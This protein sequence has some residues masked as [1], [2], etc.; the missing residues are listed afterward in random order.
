MSA[1]NLTYTNKSYEVV[2]HIVQI[3]LPASATL[4][5][6]LGALW[7]LPRA[8]EVS[9]TITALALFLGVTLLVSNKNYH[10]EADGVIN[11]EDK[12]GGG[13]LFDLVLNQE[14][15]DLKDRSKVV[16]MVNKTE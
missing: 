16:F 4:Y 14:P 6:T 10:K 12:V 9:G 5:I 3:V 7:N 13:T 8:E 1:T 15:E 2:K 11:V